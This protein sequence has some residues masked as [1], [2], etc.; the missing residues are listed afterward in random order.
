MSTGDITHVS[1][2]DE[3]H[4]NEG[5]YRSICLVSLN[6]DYMKC[7]DDELHSIIDRAGINEFKWTNLKSR[8]YASFAKEICDFAI[9]SAVRKRLRIDVLIWDMTDSRHSDVQVDGAR[10]LGIMYYHLFGNVL[11]RR[12]PDDTFWALYPD[13][14]RQIDW[15]TIEECLGQVST[16]MD[17]QSPSLFD[18]KGSIGLLR[19]FGLARVCPVE[20]QDQPLLQLAD[21]FAGLSVFSHKEY[22]GYVEWQKANPQRPLLL[23]LEDNP[24]AAP[25]TNRLRSRFSVLQYF[26]SQCKSNKLGVSLKT[27]QG[28]RTPDPSNP[29]N[30]WM[31]QPQH[32]ADRAPH[33]A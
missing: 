3:S 2:S 13:R 20:S 9:R 5:H 4:W 31:Y 14:N 29:M 23:Q 27:Q 21:L 26:D 25:L 11:R 12:W 1:F 33:K 22:L 7:L 19:E 8:P 32:L 16:Q 18:H 17:F 10:N 15:E 30:F 28:L 6:K 24:S